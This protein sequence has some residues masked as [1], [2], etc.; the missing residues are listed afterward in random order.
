MFAV[1]LAAILAPATVGADEVAAYLERHGLRELLALHLEEQLA[2]APNTEREAIAVRLASLYAELL[3]RATGVDE[4]VDL[5]TRSRRLLDV[6]PAQDAD[7]LRLALLRGRYAAAERTAEAHRLRLTDDDQVAEAITILSE[8][9]PE[10]NVARSSLREKLDTAERRIERST[11]GS[12]EQVRLS[13]QAERLR[14]LHTQAQFLTAWAMYY[15]GWLRGT[16]ETARV[17]EALF[18]EIITPDVERFRWEEVSTDLL[19]VEVFARSVLGMALCRSLTSRLDDA[20]VGIDMISADP[21]HPALMD[22]APAWRLTVL[23]EHGEF[24]ESRR[25]LNELSAARPDLPVAWIRLA[26]GVA[27]EA[28]ARS[29]DAANLAREAVAD[30]AARGELQQVLDLANRYGLDALGSSGFAALYVRGAKNYQE[31]RDLHDD[32]APTQRSDLLPL[33]QVAAESFAEAVRQG[34]AAQF[35]EAAA[36]ARLLIGW[37]RYFS[38]DFLAARDAF[39]EAA[40]TLGPAEAPEALWMAIVSLDHVVAADPSSALANEL[41]ALIA[42]FLSEHPSSEYAPRLVLRRAERGATPASIEQVEELLAVPPDSASWD[43]AQRRAEQMLYELYL[44]AAGARRLDIAER[45]LDLAV[46]LWSRQDLASIQADDAASA[47]FVVR[48]RRILEV[49]LWPGVDRVRAAEET[50]SRLEESAALG[51]IDLGPFFGE[52]AYRRVQ[53][54]IAGGDLSRAAS[55]VEESWRTEAA[56]PWTVAALKAVFRELAALARNQADASR[57]VLDQIVRY[58]GWIIRGIEGDGES[59]ESGG[60]IGYYAVTADSAFELWRRDGAPDMGRR[61]LVLYKRLLDAKPDNAAFLRAV[62]RL[63]AAFDEPALALECWRTVSAGTA[64]GSDG[65]FE[66]KYHQ[67]DILVTL[68]STQA[69]AVFEQTR[70]LY[71]DLGGEAWQARFAELG[72]KIGA[73]DQAGHNA[74]DAR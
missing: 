5:E 33:Y 69:R 7:E 8:A 57:G 6:V 11:P 17:A 66:A 3:E 42:R 70:A 14:R 15:Q 20:L 44:N 21:T 73:T 61:A 53:I 2:S 39:E 28:A 64:A 25:I 24:R 46:P 62:G 72:E 47:A 36:G 55:L 63:A 12:P 29:S 54:A 51:S 9:I 13:E 16:P 30:L 18:A 60:M 35:P 37:C 56:S 34:D 58:G 27:L 43:A 45:Y 59:V 74:E 4:R 52:I 65:W 32:D 38:G 19:A 49:A 31:A 50:L 48:G 68:D 71:P 23:L 67:I 10:F 22:Q 40:A 26:A 1:A 41:D